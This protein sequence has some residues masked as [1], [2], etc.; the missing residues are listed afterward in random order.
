MEQKPL[1]FVG[2]DIGTSFIK[3]AVLDVESRSIRHIQRTPFP[4]PLPGLNPLFCEY[5]PHH[6]LRSVQACL[7]DL[8]DR[9][10]GCD[11]IVFCNQMHSMVLTGPDGELRSNC[12]GWRDQRAQMPH[13]SFHGTFYELYLQRLH[14]AQKRVLGN[15]RPVGTPACFLFWMAEQ[16][17]LQ[18]GV[19]AVAL[20]SFVL[21]QLCRSAPRLDPTNAMAYELFNLEAMAWHKDVVDTL[22]LQAVTLPPVV[23]QGEIVGY[24]DHGGKRIPC[25]PS[26]GDYQCALAGASLRKGDL[27]LNISTG[28]QVSRI[29]DN[30]HL[31]DFQS[32]PYFDGRFTST[33]THLP[34]GRA[35]NILVDLLTELPR[36]AGIPV[37]DPWTSIV[38]AAAKAK[39]TDLDVKT[40]FF[41]G[42]RGVRG[43]ISNIGENNFNV[44]SLFRAAFRDMAENYHACAMQIWPEQ[45]WQKIV[46]S[47]GLAHKIQPLRQEIEHRFGTEAELCPIT[48]DTLSGLLMMAMSFS[49]NVTSMEQARTEIEAVQKH[50]R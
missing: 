22:G 32:R 37:R 19:A 1:S 9:A 10:E 21:G 24:L 41:P 8:L 18:P 49:G 7:F 13:P 23:P 39:Q 31:G 2:V 15:E 36:A 4:D 33:V 5:D 47:G 38:S 42:P 17:L 45:S 28:S 44:G 34:A 6:I 11:G 16:H 25:Y 50:S 14:P 43:N 35:L 20:G 30:L 48:E 26:V 29:R 12:I 3:G 27:S 40:T 46:L